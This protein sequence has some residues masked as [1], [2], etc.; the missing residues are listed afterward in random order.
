MKALALLPLIAAGCAPTNYYYSFDLTNPGAQNLS[1]PGERDTLEDSNVKAEILVDPTT[2]RAI[3]LDLKNKTNQVMEVQW[4]QIK[5]IAPDGSSLPV[6]PDAALG[7][8]LR[9]YKVSSRLVPYSL[10]ASG[11]AAA[12]YD[13]MHFELDVPLVILGQ[14]KLYQFQMIVHMQKL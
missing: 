2:F 1:K 11:D 3:A 5:M 4:T 8:V 6:Q 7:V 13:N 9:G 12:A 14:P 10:P